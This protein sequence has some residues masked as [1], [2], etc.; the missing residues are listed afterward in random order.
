MNKKEQIS[1]METLRKEYIKADNFINRK[2]IINRIVD[3]LNELESLN[4]RPEDL[5]PIKKRLLGIEKSTQIYN[6]S[7]STNKAVLS[8]K[9]V[10]SR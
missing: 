3:F 7:L 8:K 6:Y 2:Y 10:I 5:N 9:M 4:Y 1:E